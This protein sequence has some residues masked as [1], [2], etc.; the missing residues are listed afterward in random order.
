MSDV[1]Y[2]ATKYI[3]AE[4]TLLAREEKPRK[5]EREE[6]ARQEIGWKVRRTGDGQEDR[7]SKTPSARFANFTLLNIPIDQV[8]MQIKD[9]GS[10]IF[11][12]KLKG[13]PNKRPRDKYCRFHRHHGHDTF[14]C[15]D[16]KQQIEAL[17]RQGNCRGLVPRMACMDDPV[18]GFSEEDAQR[19]HHPHDD[20]LVV[21]IQIGYYNTHRVLV[22]NDNFADII[23]YPAFQQMRIRFGGT[24]VYP[25][26]LGLEVQGIPTDA[27]FIGFGGTRVYPLGA[28]TLF[29]T[30]GDYPQQIT[31][32][33]TFLVV[34]YSF[35]YNAILGRPTLTSWKV[36]TSTYHLMIKFPIEYKVGEVRGNQVAARECYIAMIEMDDHLPTMCIEERRMVTEIVEGIEEVPF[37]DSKPK[38]MTKIGIL[39]SLPV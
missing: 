16:L 4:D 15:Y 27:P 25:L 39:A 37:D 35:A 30:V 21:S 3:N 26:G 12:G 6:D 18:I 2:R 7:R 17:I 11:P 28:V 8:L 22:D 31:R 38:W 29:V 24:R 20:T 36:V 32:D 19:L 23:Y 5:R 33:V 13:D 14:K 34:D 9:K 1:L 10:L